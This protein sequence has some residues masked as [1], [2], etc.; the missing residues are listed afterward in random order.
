MAVACGA[1]GVVLGSGAAWVAVAWG[2]AGVGAGVRGPAGVGVACPALAGRSV[3]CGLAAV[4]CGLAV[5]VACRGGGSGGARW[6]PAGGRAGQAAPGIWA[7]SAGT[8]ARAAG[9][10]LTAGLEATPASYRYRL[11][12]RISPISVAP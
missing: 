8:P 3:A 4:A 6:A 5:A 1:A 7:A 9:A 10:A 2:A 11:Y 12:C